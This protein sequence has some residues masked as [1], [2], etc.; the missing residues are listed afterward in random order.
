MA[1]PLTSF[2][3]GPGQPDEITDFSTRR[4]KPVISLILPVL[5]EAPILAAALSNLPQAPDLEIILVDGGSTDASRE[6]AGGFPHVRWLTAPRG[7]GGQMN[8][9]A[10]VARGDFFLFLH[11]DT[12]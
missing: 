4:L 2:S 8:A 6:V 9:G 5:N 1:F 3:A 11:I 10:R 7:R 12:V